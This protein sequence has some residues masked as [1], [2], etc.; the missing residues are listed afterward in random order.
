[1]LKCIPSFALALNWA[2]TSGWWD[3]SLRISLFL[4]QI[5]SFQ[6]KQFSHAQHI[7]ECQVEN[8]SFFIRMHKNVMFTSQ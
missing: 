7:C 3:W 4:D 5:P 8:V 6:K 2:P 1:M